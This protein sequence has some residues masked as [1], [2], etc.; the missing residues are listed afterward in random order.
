MRT[1]LCINKR[2]GDPIMVDY[3]GQLLPNCDNLTHHCPD[4]LME[5][6]KV[7]EGH[8]NSQPASNSV[9]VDD[10]IGDQ[11]T[12]SPV[13]LCDPQPMREHRC[14]LPRPE[15]GT[16]CWHSPGLQLSDDDACN[17]YILIQNLGVK[18]L[19]DFQF[20]IPHQSGVNEV[21]PIK[22]EIK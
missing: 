16:T 2:Y 8:E 20:I 21:L 3:P 12:S 1:Y 22:C 14:R 10:L 4:C 18:V 15:A 17:D 19:K 11:T 7:R 9:T 5:E 6:N 13:A